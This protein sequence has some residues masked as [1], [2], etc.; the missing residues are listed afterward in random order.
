MSAQTSLSASL[1]DWT[2]LGKVA[3]V[4]FVFGV[5]IVVLFSVG[6]IGVSWLRGHDA[7]DTDPDQND[8]PGSG[9]AVAANQPLGATL[10]VV[11]FGLCA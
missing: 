8:V 11:C 9:S 1:I 2:S 6:I 5:A 10:A 4:S 3:G 7:P